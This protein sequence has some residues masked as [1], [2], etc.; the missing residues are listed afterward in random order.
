MN[1][2]AILLQ[3][4]Y[5]AQCTTSEK[6]V[7]TTQL[8]KAVVNRNLR[9]L[10]ARSFVFCVDDHEGRNRKPGGK[11]TNA[12][13]MMNCEVPMEPMTIEQ[14]LTALG[15]KGNRGDEILRDMGLGC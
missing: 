9:K 8:S 7:E 2:T 14:A 5:V 12:L 11:Y 3:A 1:S 15:T 4:L 6:L 13:W 10:A